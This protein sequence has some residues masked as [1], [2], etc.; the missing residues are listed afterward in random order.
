MPNDLLARF[1]TYLLHDERLGISLDISRMRF[2]DGFF[3]GMEPRMQKAFAAMEALERGAI[4][5]PDEKRMVG[6]YWLRAPELAPEPELR[7][8]IR[9]TLARSARRSRRRCTPARVQPAARRAASRNVLVVGIG[10]SALGPQFVAD[11]LGTPG[12]SRCGA[13]FLDN[14][15]PDGMDRVFDAIGDGLAETLTVVISKSGGTKETRNGMLEAAAPTSG[16]PR[17]RQARRGRHGRR[18]RAGP[19]RRASTAGSRASPCGT[20]SAAA[21]ASC[22]AVGLLPARAPG[23]RH[24]R[25]ARRRARAWTRPRARTTTRENPAALLALMWYSRHRR[26]GPQGHG[27][28]ALQG[29]AAAV[30]PLPPAARDGVAGQAARPRRQ[31]GAPGHRRLRQQ[32]LDRPAR[33]RAA[34]PRRA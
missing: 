3:A 13:F 34:A 2:A 10:G 15:D 9:D 23:H 20:G 4:A 1:R 6:H 11:A 33:L 8:A 32:G 16:R 21:P 22:R 28:P 25:H 26:Q 17:L 14:T 31:G 19:V 18:Q 12:G 5:N 30:L 27:R 7:E 24:R 29:P